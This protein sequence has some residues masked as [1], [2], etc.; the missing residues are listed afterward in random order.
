MYT[1]RTA[2]EREVRALLGLRVYGPLYE[3]G[4]DSS[5][6]SRHSWSHATHSH[7]GASGQPTGPS[8]LQKIRAGRA[9]EDPDHLLRAAAGA[10]AGS[11]H[12]SLH[13][14]AVASWCTAVARSA[15]IASFKPVGAPG[16][17]S[18][19]YLPNVGEEQFCELRLNGVL[20]SS[21]TRGPGFHKRAMMPPMFAHSY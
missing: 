11:V 19:P 14:K 17:F 18:C 20:R 12:T 7:S 4:P 1:Q 8:I 2:A 9:V 21:R 10:S 3:R 16:P 5:S 13:D 6:P 15:S